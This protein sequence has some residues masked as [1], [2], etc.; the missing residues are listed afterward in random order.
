MQDKDQGIQ[1]KIG[2]TPATEPTD[3]KFPDYVTISQHAIPVFP[4]QFLV[5]PLT[6]MHQDERWH[7]FLKGIQDEKTH[8]ILQ[9]KTRPV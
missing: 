7:N 2:Q 3:A 9:P 1:E 6:H 4:K 8:K 5:L